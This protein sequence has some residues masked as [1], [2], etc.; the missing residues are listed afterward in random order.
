[1][2]FKLLIHVPVILKIPRYIEWFWTWPW[3]CLVFRLIGSASKLKAD[4]LKEIL[5][6]VLALFPPWTLHYFVSIFIWNQRDAKILLLPS[7]LKN[8]VSI[9]KFSFYPFFFANVRI[10]IFINELIFFRAKLDISY[11]GLANLAR[12]LCFPFCT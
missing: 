10:V 2:F 5:F 8:F 7:P 12:T 11:M 4:K 9:L 3:I 1:M 6:V